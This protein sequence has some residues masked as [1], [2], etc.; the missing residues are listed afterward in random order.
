MFSYA[1]AA[2]EKITAEDDPYD[3]EADPGGGTHYDDGDTGGG[4]DSSDDTPVVYVIT[5]QGPI[6]PYTPFTVTVNTDDGKSHKGQGGGHLNAEFTDGSEFPFQTRSE[7]NWHN[8]SKTYTLITT[9]KDST[10]VGARFQYFVSGKENP[11]CTIAYNAGYMV[12]DITPASVRPYKTFAFT[13]KFSASANGGPVTDCIGS[14]AN[15][16]AT[17]SWEGY[18]GREWKPTKLITNGNV[19]GSA[20]SF[21]GTARAGALAGLK[22]IRICVKYDGRDVAYDEADVAVEG[23]EI[24]T[25]PSSLHVFGEA[26]TLTIFVADLAVADAGNVAVAVFN[27]DDEPV[28][29]DDVFEDED[30]EDLDFSTGWA[31]VSGGIEWTGTIQ[32]KTSVVGDIYTLQVT[33]A[34]KS[35][36]ADIDVI[37]TLYGVI[38]APEEAY[39]YVPFDVTVS[40]MGGEHG[41]MRIP[42]IPTE[43]LQFDSTATIDPQSSWIYDDS[44]GGVEFAAR[45]TSDEVEDLNIYLLFEYYEITH[46]VVEIMSIESAL[47]EAINER[48]I[49]KGSS[50]RASVND[51]PSTLRNKAIS[52]MGGYAKGSVA[53]DGSF[54]QYDSSNHELLDV[55]ETY[56]HLPDWYVDAYQKV[57]SA[58]SRSISLTVNSTESKTRSINYDGVD[59]YIHPQND[60]QEGEQ[61]EQQYDYIVFESMTSL[62]NRGISTMHEQQFTN[63]N[64][65]NSYVAF[66]VQSLQVRSGFVYYRDGTHQEGGTSN[67]YK[68][69]DYWGSSSVY[70]GETYVRSKY[71]V[72]PS[73]DGTVKLYGVSNYDDLIGNEFGTFGFNVPS[74]KGVK[75]NFYTFEVSASTAN[76][77]DWI[78][79]IGASFDAPWVNT[80]PNHEAFIS[81]T[82]G[83]Y[84]GYQ[85]SNVSAVITF[86]FNHK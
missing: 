19:T 48:F 84:K 64:N 85:L 67:R 6:L 63:Y 45:V 66:A 83:G 13:V 31:E 37:D 49:G 41:D 80:D 17:I 55:P 33:C 5:G 25:C 9:A 74:T 10:K 32:A 8:G 73:Y 81:D 57:C 56:T 2:K 14:W 65:Y 12:P 16:G 62:R 3:P 36:T 79:G 39:Q 26:D 71:S 22:K 59:Q 43:Y 28:D 40:V 34:D 30:G 52:A 46:V 44:T 77:T 51:S 86:D 38:D 4:D 18:D 47:A 78:G 23:V 69:I 11:T 35:D 53:S 20:G 1:F 58:V 68:Q 61:S 21:S 50:S 60:Q 54:T 82:Y 42:R 75:K 72:S 70:C 27:S 29:I 24:V 7:T 15:L 76:V